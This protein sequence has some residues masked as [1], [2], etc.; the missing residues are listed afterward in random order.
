[1]ATKPQPPNAPTFKNLEGGFS[2]LSEIDKISDL[3]IL[4]SLMMANITDQTVLPIIVQ[5]M[6][7]VQN[8]AIAKLSKEKQD[9]EAKL[10]QKST[11]T[12]SQSESVALGESLVKALKGFIVD[13]EN[14]LENQLDL[15]LALITFAQSKGI[16]A[17]PE[18]VKRFESVQLPEDP[19]TLKQGIAYGLCKNLSNNQTSHWLL[20]IDNPFV[21][22]GK[23][24][25]KPK[26]RKE[27]PD[28]LVSFYDT[29]GKE[30]LADPKELS[31]QFPLGWIVDP[32]LG[33]ELV[34]RNSQSYMN[35]KKAK[36]QY[37]KKT[38]LR[39]KD[40]KVVYVLAEWS[41]KDQEAWEKELAKKQTT[42]ETKP[43]A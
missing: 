14:I 35:Y 26:K 38:G 18:L 9:L 33:E 21:L 6:S 40:Q 17:D 29:E 3:Q 20:M 19:Y 43:T 36:V 27:D 37:C 11:R 34:K 31:R 2:D 13:P 12:R 30:N 4:Q 7:I 28:T 8:E 15:S 22:K 39:T 42:E 41:V 25:F 16:T 1:M 23:Q 24:W 32:T 5:R 10:A